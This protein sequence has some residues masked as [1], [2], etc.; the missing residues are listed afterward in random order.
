MTITQPISPLL[1][2]KMNLNNVQTKKQEPVIQQQAI[3]STQYKYSP[4]LSQTVLAQ[5]KQILPTTSTNAVVGVTEAQKAVPNYKNNLKEMLTTNKAQILA[6]IPR[7]MNAQ[8]KDG[9]ELIQ[10]DEIPGNFINAIERL[11]EIKDLGFNTLHVLPI[12]PTGKS[13]AMGTAGS[14]YAP[15]DFLTFDPELVDENPPAA[16]RKRIEEIYEQS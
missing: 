2:Q 8:D 4:L 6:V 9:N 11:D 12:H 1:A 5:T 3:V 15:K 7:I 16:A 10:G 14:L 13:K